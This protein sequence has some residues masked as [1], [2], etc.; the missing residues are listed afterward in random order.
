MV[1]LL[2]AQAETLPSGLKAIGS[3]GDVAVFLDLMR[4]IGAVD[5]IRIQP[6]FETMTP[7]QMQLE[8]FN[9]VASLDE[10]VTKW[11]NSLTRNKG[12]TRARERIGQVPQENK[13]GPAPGDP[14]S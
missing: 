6:T 8:L 12:T 13:G 9:R 3:W 14:G 5:A 1:N 10:G 2:F 7:D 11:K 4:T